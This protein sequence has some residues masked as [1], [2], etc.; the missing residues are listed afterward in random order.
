[1]TDVVRSPAD[2][3]RPVAV[4]RVRLLSVRP[5]AFG[6]RANCR[7]PSVKGSSGPSVATES[8]TMSGHPCLFLSHSGVDTEAARELKRRLLEAPDAIAAGLKVWLDKDDLD[9]GFSWQEQLARAIT[10]DA[11]AFVVYCGSGGIVNWV[12]S[13]VE[14]ALSRATT[15]PDFPFIPA[16]APGAKVTDL[17]PFAQRFQ[18]V[19]DPLGSSEQLARLVRTALGEE[20]RQP[21]ALISEPFVGLRAMRL[22][23]A[24][25]FFGRASEAAEVIGLLKRLPIVAV[26]AESGSGKSSLAMAGVAPAFRGGVLRDPSRTQVHDEIWHVVAMRPSASPIEGLRSAVTEA[27]QRMGLDPQTCAALRRRIDL[28]NPSEC[29]YAIRCDLAQERTRTLLIVDQFEE[30]LTQTPE[31]ERGPFLDLLIWLADSSGRGSFSILLTWRSDYLN[32][33]APYLT[34]AARLNAH[35]GESIYRLRRISERGLA[36]AI[37]EPLKLAGHVDEAEQKALVQL[38]S[39]DIMDSPGNLALVQMALYAVWRRKSAHGHGLVKTY[40]AIGGLSGALASQADEVRMARLDDEERSLLLPVLSRLVRLGNTGGATRRIA[41]FEEFDSKRQALARRLATDECARLL[42]V[43]ETTVEVAHEALITQWSWLQ[44]TLND[45]TIASA[46]RSLDSLEERARAYETA[47]EAAKGAYVATGAELAAFE[48][49]GSQHAGW[50]SVSELEF[51]DRS[52]THSRR[53]NRVRKLLLYASL[54]L[55][56]VLAVVSGLAINSSRRA[57][58]AALLA[59][60]ATKVAEAERRSAT[61]LSEDLRKML[62]TRAAAAPADLD[63]R[64]D[65]LRSGETTFGRF[66]ADAFRRASD[67]DFAFIPSGSIRS[68]RIIQKDQIIAFYDLLAAFPFSNEVVRVDVDGANILKALELG[69][70]QLEGDRKTFLHVSGGT[71][72][73]DPTRPVGRRVLSVQLAGKELTPDRRYSVAMQTFNLEGGDGYTM[74][75]DV[76]RKHVVIGSDILVVGMA[77]AGSMIQDINVQR[78]FILGR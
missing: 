30:L 61:R 40:A 64:R 55:S 77:L 24:S 49:L 10:V 1:M 67:A 29:S 62:S 56:L 78:V 6:P 72:T 32:L 48:R 3:D 35:E 60:A 54:A 63:A 75:K 42:V 71:I 73:I 23:D 25:L 12:E 41:R 4:S 74:F 21:V 16:I 5:T 38:I 45:R 22:H 50:L 19:F 52:A 15:S 65:K 36:A 18:C 53:T 14:V 70:S 66:A 44:N 39:R 33:I 17:P 13:E 68:D 8:L 11:T 7:N 46:L 34:F 37:C 20:K 69:F 57:G 2:S 27:A 47:S 31:A 51:V 9:P 76:S 26:V 58:E 59:E 43:G 28:S